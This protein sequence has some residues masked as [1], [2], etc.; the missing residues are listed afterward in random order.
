MK[1]KH[2]FEP[3]V[4]LALILLM[5]MPLRVLAEAN[6]TPELFQQEELDQMLAPIALYPDSLLAQIFMASTYPLEVVQAERWVKQNAHLQGDDLAVA[7]ESQRWDPSVKSLLNFPRVLAMMSEEL[8]WTTNL[9]DAFLAQEADVLGTVQR[10]RAKAQAAGNLQTT[11][12]QQVIVEQQVIRIESVSPQIVYV[13]TYNPTVVYGPWWYPTYPPHYYYP[14]GY[15]AGTA[16][17]SF[18]SGVVVGSAWGY[19]WGGFNWHRHHVVIN[20]HRNVH[21]N[22]HI[23]RERHRAGFRHR[24]H[25]DA[26]GRGRWRHNAVHRRG[27]TYRDQAT[28]RRFNRGTAAARVRARKHF[29]GR[30]APHR[31]N[32]TRGRTE[33]HRGRRVGKR[34]G[35]RARR[36]ENRPQATSPARGGR[37]A[38]RRFGHSR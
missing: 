7:L 6:N 34:A 22:R 36:P 30:P 19:A 11:T 12:E 29:R 37:R 13:P 31:Q 17:F 4:P 23:N 16:L 21:R 8:E 24:G 10:L 1:I 32:V 20:V 14:P 9:G 2:V 3:L 28:A 15:V 18:G 26:R 25:I 35:V 38:S 5:A 33:Q 27:V